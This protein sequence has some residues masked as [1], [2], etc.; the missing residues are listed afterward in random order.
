MPDSNYTTAARVAFIERPSM[1]THVR[2]AITLHLPHIILVEGDA[3]I[4][5]TTL[6]N[7]AAEIGEA[8][9]MFTVPL[10]DFYDTRVHSFQGLEHFIAEP[11][12]SATGAFASYWEAR[13]REPQADLWA[14]FREGYEK[15][16]TDRHVLLRFDTVERLI[17]ERDP[18]AVLRDCE[19]EALDAPSWQWLLHRVGD[20]PNTTVL[21][22][23]RPT[24]QLLSTK[25]Q[26]THGKDRFQHVVIEG[27][28]LQETIGYFC[29][30]EYGRQ[31]VEDSPE[32]AEKIHLLTDGRPIL[33]A[34]AL[35]WLQRGMWDPR[36]YPLEA[37]ELHQ[38][39]T[40]AQNNAPTGVADWEEIKHHF[41][42]AL[43][44][45]IR[46]LET[47]LDVAVR[48]VALCRKGCNAQLLS[49]LMG[50]SLSDAESLVAK[51][52][53]LSFVKP[54]RPG[55][56][57]MF[58]LHDEMYDLVER[59]V[60]WA[61]YGADYSEQARLDES[62]SDWYSEQID[63]LTEAI[64]ESPGLHKRYELRRDQQL[65]YT[66]R[67][68]YQLDANPK[69]GYRRYCYLTEQAIDAREDEWDT[70][71]RNELF[72]F[73]ALRPMRWRCLD[74]QQISEMEYDARRHC[75]SRFVA[76]ERLDHAIGVAKKLLATE[77]QPDEP[78]LY[79]AGLRIALATAQAFTG[80]SLLEDSIPNFKEGIQT[81]ESLFGE[82]PGRWLPQYLLGSAHLYKGLA[83]RG[84]RPLVE[85]RRA[86]AKA[87]QFF[88]SI[89]YRPGLAEALNNLAFVM[90]RQ[91]KL[92]QALA[93]CDEALAIRQELGDEYY[94]G[95]SLNTKGIILERL[96]RPV[97]AIHNSEQAL[98]IFTEM[99]NERGIMMAAINLGRAFRR[100]GRSP[101]WEQQE[102]D[103][104]TGEEI[105][106]AAIERSRAQG[107][108]PDTYYRIQAHNELGCLYRDWVATLHVK[109][110]RDQRVSSYLEDAR[111]NLDEAIRLAQ[112]D[113][114]DNPQDMLQ[115]I[116]SLEDLARVYYWWARAKPGNRAKHLSE[117]EQLLT[118]AETLAQDRLDERDELRLILGRICFQRAR[119]AKESGLFLEAAQNYALAAGYVE[120]YSADAPEL[121]K[122]ASDA[123]GWL[124]RFE[125]AEANTY[126]MAMREVLGNKLPYTRLQ[127]WFDSVVQ[128]LLGIDWEGEV[129][130]G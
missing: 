107:T 75:I 16:V 119:L 88:R 38:L 84:T 68:Y 93:A 3:G 100:K 2:Q 18:E 109:D 60:W 1:T 113:D 92:R 48:Y 31:V 122:F 83:L 23:A 19:A 82:K 44:Q 73:V 24:Q 49:Q 64:K 125:P 72:G 51:L 5:K 121:D 58:F 67:L 50:S 47:P 62:I 87:I 22:A 110:S 79:R 46:M 77:I 52:Q 69:S 81:I 108:N 25:L 126:L 71:L 130:H 8:R 45:Q 96:D 63:Y 98:R 26:E 14:Q 37:T 29:Q 30:S 116:D 115:Y 17:Y 21:L 111:V 33:I 66:E 106:L 70:W 114:E 32:M 76:G 20:L 54:P 53:T 11:L 127:E 59:Y 129:T 128:P 85:A 117:M 6:L 61:D 102:A 101:D 86:Y 9:G 65:L 99:G 97:T 124:A 7:W 89:E 40:A 36:L 91:G 43:V 95:L 103:F 34:L 80:G 41:E 94:I 55:S 42:A 120:S 28:D 112:G 74:R 78:P 104:K 35:D 56:R 15:A 12:G 105:L 123:S 27:F 4:G 118:K 10:I 90:A 57:G 39:K 13:K